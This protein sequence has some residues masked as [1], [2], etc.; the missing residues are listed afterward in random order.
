MFTNEIIVDA[1]KNVFWG[2]GITYS[3][4]M[5]ALIVSVRI[6]YLMYKGTNDW[7]PYK[8]AFDK[9]P[10]VYNFVSHQKL[11]SIM[12]ITAI[13]CT[14][15]FDTSYTALFY[16]EVAEA[17]QTI[18]NLEPVVVINIKVDFKIMMHYSFLVPPLLCCVSFAQYCH[19][20][21][22]LKYST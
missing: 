14:I 22:M 6:F 13:V 18:G 21:V 19:F 20:I 4:L 12:G 5:I 8:L 1:N 17:G 7:K 11:L 10:G 16:V 3:F 9:R 15:L 2:R